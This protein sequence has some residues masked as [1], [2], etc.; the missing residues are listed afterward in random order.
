M[1][2]LIV[3]IDRRVRLPLREVPLWGSKWRGM[4]LTSFLADG[5]LGFQVN[6]LLRMVLASPDWEIAKHTRA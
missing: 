3:T 5:V 2:C 4:G 6:D 1:R